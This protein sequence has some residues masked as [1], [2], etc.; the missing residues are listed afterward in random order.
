MGASCQ[1][2]LLAYLHPDQYNLKFMKASEFFT[3]SFCKKEKYKK[4]NPY[5]N[6]SGSDINKEG[7]WEYFLF[8]KHFYSISIQFLNIENEIKINFN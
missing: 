7:K 2:P 4:Y 5:G 8:I 1:L 3:V 6:E